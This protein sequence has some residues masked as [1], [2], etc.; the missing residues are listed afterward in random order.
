MTP[1]TTVNF[2][3]TFTSTDAGAMETGSFAGLTGGTINSLSGG[4]TTG[5]V[6]MPGFIKFN[7]GTASTVTFDLTYIAP[8]V[9]TQAGCASD[10][11]GNQCTPANSPF[12]LFQL[13]SNTVVA[14]LQLNGEAYT[15]PKSTGFS[16]TTGIFSTQFAMDGT[17]SGILAQLGNGGVNT[18]YSAT[19]CSVIFRRKSGCRRGIRCGRSGG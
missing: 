11:I 14:S 10:T 8:G 16:N 9:G 17:I 1:N 12:T 2:A 19:G 18:T 3:P 6:N 7:Q 15:D 4:P 13:S 5:A